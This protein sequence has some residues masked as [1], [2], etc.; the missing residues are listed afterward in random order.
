[1]FTGDRKQLWI[2]Q[3]DSISPAAE[4]PEKAPSSLP[5]FCSSSF[6]MNNRYTSCTVTC[7]LKVEREGTAV[8]C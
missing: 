2:W 4:V 3:K 8:R 5:I 6:V 1:M 7:Q